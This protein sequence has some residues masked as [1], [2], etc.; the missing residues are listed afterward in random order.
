MMEKQIA[1]EVKKHALDAVKSLS[2]ALSSCEDQCPPD[3]YQQIKKGVGLSMG[4]IETELLGIIYAAYP[5]LD[6][7][8]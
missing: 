4:T 5:E 8:G 6:D 2:K 1:N 3:E 7:L